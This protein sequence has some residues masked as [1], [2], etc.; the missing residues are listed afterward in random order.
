LN[1]RKIIGKVEEASPYPGA[2][3]CFVI[4]DRIDDK[5]WISE[6]VRVTAAELPLP[7]PKTAK[8]RVH[9]GRAKQ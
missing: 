7:K 8:K 5:E 2:K 4:R 3:P 9:K 6:L 1:G